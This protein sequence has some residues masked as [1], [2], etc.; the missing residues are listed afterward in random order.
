MADKS[1]DMFKLVEEVEKQKAMDIDAIFSDLD[2]VK[3]EEVTTVKKKVYASDTN[4]TAT[5]SKPRIPDQIG[6]FETRFEAFRG[7]IEHVYY[8]VSNVNVYVE[9]HRDALEKYY[10]DAYNNSKDLYVIE[11]RVNDEINRYG[12][13]SQLYEKGYYDGL[14]YVLKALKRSK[15]LLM[16]KLNSEINRNL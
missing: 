16:T 4:T 5:V 8:G 10:K 14:F 1:I 9:G 15:E 2:S 6:S 12:T 7:V 3:N 11:A 13:H